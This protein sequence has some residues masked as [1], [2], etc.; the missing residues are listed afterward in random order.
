MTAPQTAWTLSVSQWPGYL[1]HE[2]R[3]TSP[4]RAEIRSQEGFSRICAEV[5]HEGEEYRFYVARPNGQAERTQIGRSYRSVRRADRFAR[6]WVRRNFIN[7]AAT[8]ASWWRTAGAFLAGILAVALITPSNRPPTLV[9]GERAMSSSTYQPEQTSASAPMTLNE[10]AP[11]GEPQLNADE[12]KTIQTIGAAVGIPLG[13][14]ASTES[15]FVFADPLCPYCHAMQPAI[16]A[17]PVAQRPVIIPVGVRGQLSAEL[18]ASYFEA[19]DR[20]GQAAGRLWLSFMDPSFDE[21][22]AREVVSQYPASDASKKKA[23]LTLTLFSKLGF[24]KTPTLVSAGGRLSGPINEV[25][26]LRTWLRFPEAE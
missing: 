12:L 19:V 7:R 8:P 3:K 22:R 25:T 9:A 17:L 15:W 24:K 23:F 10:S 5:V 14:P 11:A 6:A 21:T 16:D 4:Y 13:T 2:Q 1:V 20:D 18:I 26:E